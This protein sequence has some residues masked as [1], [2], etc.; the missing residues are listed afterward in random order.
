MSMHRLVI[1]LFSFCFYLS[2]FLFLAIHMLRAKPIG[3]GLACHHSAASGLSFTVTAAATYAP[4]MHDRANPPI[5]LPAH[6]VPRL[7]VYKTFQ[8]LQQGLHR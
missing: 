8:P 1:M 7:K 4:Q 6:L 3:Y 5:C 2:L